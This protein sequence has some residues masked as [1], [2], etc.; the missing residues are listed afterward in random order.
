LDE[1]SLASNWVAWWQC[2]EYA[3]MTAATRELRPR[4]VRKICWFW[5]LEHFVFIRQ[6]LSNHGVTRLKRFISRITAKLCS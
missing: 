2:G 6:T 5:V 4:L 3:T 1:S